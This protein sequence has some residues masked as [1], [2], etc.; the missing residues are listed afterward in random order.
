VTTLEI[1]SRIIVWLIVGGVI[2]LV[3]GLRSRYNTGWLVVS[4]A[5]GALLLGFATLVFDLLPATALENR[6]TMPIYT[7]DLMLAAG[8]G[9]IAALIV[10]IV[11]RG[12]RRG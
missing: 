10:A 5:V 4:G 3:V 7:A 12:S 8:A 9:F 1:F 6:I 2:G 11:N